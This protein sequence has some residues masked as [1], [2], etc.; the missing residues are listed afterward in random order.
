M[1]WLIFRPCRRDGARPEK[2]PVTY[3][4]RSFKQKQKAAVFGLVL[5]GVALQSAL[6]SAGLQ[7]WWRGG[8]RTKKRAHSILSP[9]P[10]HLTYQQT[11]CFYIRLGTNYRA[12]LVCS[13]FFHIQTHSGC[14]ILLPIIATCTGR[15]IPGRVVLE[16]VQCLKVW[17]TVFKTLPAST[18]GSYR[19]WKSHLVLIKIINSLWNDMKRSFLVVVVS[20]KACHWFLW[21]AISHSGQDWWITMLLLHVR[22]QV[23]CSLWKILSMLNVKNTIRF[24]QALQ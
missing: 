22:D 12:L 7:T 21:A 18:S 4:G 3:W 23:S 20:N 6:L 9:Y 19:A 1:Y 5:A 17:Q 24:I 14:L 16:T 8:A 10:S 2:E 15:G 13:V 11:A